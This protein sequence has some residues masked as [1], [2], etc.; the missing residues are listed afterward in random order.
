MRKVFYKP[1]FIVSVVAA[2]TMFIAG[3]IVLYLYDSGFSNASNVEQFKFRQ[4]LIVGA[5]FALATLVIT[6]LCLLCEVVNG[7]LNGLEWK[8]ERAL[9][10]LARIPIF[11][12]SIGLIACLFQY[13][14]SMDFSRQELASDYVV[15][16]DFSGSMSVNDP[17][18]NRSDAAQELAR[19][20]T[21]KNRF[22]VYLFSNDATQLSPLEYM[23]DANKDATIG[24][25]KTAE[26]GGGSTDV[27]H[28]VDTVMNDLENQFQKGKITKVI[29]LSDGLDN[30]AV[31]LFS[32][33]SV[34]EKYRE[35]NVVIDTVL[36][37][38]IRGMRF[39]QRLAH[40]TNGQAVFINDA[41]RLANTYTMLTQT[42]S[43]RNLIKA[44][45]GLDSDRN[46][47]KFMRIGF[48]AIL[49]ILIA[50]AV[51]FTM[52][53]RRFFF[54]MMC[55]GVIAGVLAGLLL[56]FGFST[57]LIHPAILRGVM[58]LIILSVF[59]WYRLG[60]AIHR[61]R[62]IDGG[63]GLS[64]RSCGGGRSLSEFSNRSSVIRRPC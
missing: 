36:L 2:T 55:K 27:Y 20:M 13:I 44:R 8:R 56:E 21:D 60:G 5:F 54:E 35:K 22:A 61:F 64:G 30:G 31:N 4:I 25:L 50:L 32:E 57:D 43:D 38:D 49:G 29:L 18:D 58:L 26:Y 47:Y 7:R 24:A 16:I 51:S 33:G 28:A 42:T 12:V 63:S 34:L 3:E 6:L 15:L 39:M 14:Y 46:L 62:S 52:D 10:M 19:L 45:F 40:Q 17:N 37:S 23:T 48:I 1:L 41:L 59:A 9:K 53:N 11:V